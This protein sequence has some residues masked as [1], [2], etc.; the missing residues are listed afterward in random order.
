MIVVEPQPARAVKWRHVQSSHAVKGW[1]PRSWDV[2]KQVVVSVRLE[3]EVAVE[4]TIL[5]KCSQLDDMKLAN[6]SLEMRLIQ[7]RH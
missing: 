2:E 7:T 4:S 3:F 6:M 5:Q 1:F